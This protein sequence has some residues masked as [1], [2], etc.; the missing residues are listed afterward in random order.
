MRRLRQAFPEQAS[1][2]A[3][4]LTCALV[5]SFGIHA[6]LLAL[7]GLRPGPSRL[8]GTVPLQATLVAIPQ[9]TNVLPAARQ[10]NVVPEAPAPAQSPDAPREVAAES[11]EVAA[12]DPSAEAGVPA[13]RDPV[14]YEA[15]ELDTYPQLRDPLSPV[16]PQVALS[17]GIAGAVTVLV[18]IDETGKVTEASVVDAKPEGFFDDSARRALAQASFLPASREGRS[19]RS[20]ILISVSYD[21]DK[22]D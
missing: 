20:R 11:A 8:P 9:G 6:A 7:P 10:S 13:L 5:V 18:L 19:V 21:P 17:Q 22:P 14:H 4:R 1:S 2:A 16:Y 12:L 15:K 3:T